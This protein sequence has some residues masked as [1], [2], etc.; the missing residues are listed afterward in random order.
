M[1]RFI[2]FL[3][4][5]ST[6][7][8]TLGQRNKRGGQSEERPSR[9][10]M[11]IAAYEHALQLNDFVTAISC[12]NYVVSIDGKDS[13]LSDTLLLLYCTKGKLLQTYNLAMQLREDGRDKEWSKRCLPSI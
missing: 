10:A 1:K 4:I 11:H 12:V 3:M 7:N 5:V 6:A 9:S 8:V 2:L 13:P